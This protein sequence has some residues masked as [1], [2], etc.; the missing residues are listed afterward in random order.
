MISNQN[1]N[2]IICGHVTQDKER[3]RALEIMMD[4]QIQT[5]KKMIQQK[6]KYYNWKSIF[7]NC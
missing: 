4:I 7:L 2:L 3:K 5:D 1:V 6:R